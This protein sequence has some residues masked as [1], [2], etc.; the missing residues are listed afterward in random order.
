MKLNF[1]GSYKTT[2]REKRIMRRDFRLHA[3]QMM[4]AGCVEKATIW[5]KRARNG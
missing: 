2:S 3:K 5:L 4:R 1:G